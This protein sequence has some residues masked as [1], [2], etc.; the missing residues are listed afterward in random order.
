MPS[1]LLRLSRLIGLLAILCTP[2]NGLCTENSVV[3]GPRDFT[4]GSWGVHVSAHRF[5][6]DASG[7]GTLVVSRP[8]SGQRFWGGFVL[9]NE[10]FYS[11]HEFL[12]GSQ[13]VFEAGVNLHKTNVIGLSLIGQPG[14]A[15]SIEGRAGN[16]V[17]PPQVTFSATPESITPGQASTL[18]WT[19]SEAQSITIEPGLGAVAPSGSQTVS[20]A[21]TTTYTLTAAGLGGTATRTATVT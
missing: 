2:I 9:V 3:F 6:C 11:L 1:G 16:S 21:A 14:A 15:V 12:E 8:A 5:A 7:E 13:A 20:P 17:M 18:S 4:V 19:T 10:S